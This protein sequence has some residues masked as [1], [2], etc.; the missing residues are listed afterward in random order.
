MRLETGMLKFL[1]VELIDE[2]VFLDSLYKY[3]STKKNDWVTRKRSRIQASK[4]QAF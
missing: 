4:I 1:N 3:K 2:D